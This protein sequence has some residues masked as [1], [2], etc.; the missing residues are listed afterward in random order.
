MRAESISPSNFN[1]QK[2]SN[3]FALTYR[4]INNLQTSNSQSFGSPAHKD[5][6]TKA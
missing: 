1:K 5:V 2:Y 3:N 4:G 6:Q